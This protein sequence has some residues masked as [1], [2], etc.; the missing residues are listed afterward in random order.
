METH[1]IPPPGKGYSTDVQGIVDTL[2][3]LRNVDEYANSLGFKNKQEFL[4]RIPL[5]AKVLDIGSG[6]DGF[7]EAM[8]AERPDVLVINLNPS[9]ANRT[10]RN[11]TIRTGRI[12]EDSAGINPGLPYKKET[13]DVVLDSMA[14]IYYADEFLGKP[15]REVLVEK[16]HEIIRV[17]KP[18]AFAAVGPLFVKVEID[19]FMED[20]SKITGIKVEKRKTEDST[21]MFAFHITK[22]SL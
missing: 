4:S 16:V 1:D 6:D 13:F 14:S 20:T 9:M 22:T 17:M 18:G 2:A 11:L 8:K 10:H 19:G 21:R 12:S 7:S 5:N 3:T 15:G